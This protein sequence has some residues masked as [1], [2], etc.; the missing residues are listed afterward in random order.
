MSG[1]NDCNIILVENIPYDTSETK[2]KEIFQQVGPIVS[3]R[4]IR[5]LNNVE[6]EGQ[7]LKVGYADNKSSTITNEVYRLNPSFKSSAQQLSQQQQKL[8]QQSSNSDSDKSESGELLLQN[9]LLAYDL[10][11]ILFQLDL[12]DENILKKIVSEKQP[13]RTSNTTTPIQQPIQPIQPLPVGTNLNNPF[14]GELQIQEQNAALILQLLNLTPQQIDMFPPDQRNRILTLKNLRQSTS[15]MECRLDNDDKR[16][17]VNILNSTFTG[18]LRFYNVQI[19]YIST[20]GKF[21]SKHRA[22]LTTI[23]LQKKCPRVLDWSSYSPDLNPI[24]NLW[25]IIKKKSEWDNLNPDLLSNLCAC[26]KKRLEE[27]IERKDV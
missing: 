16:V 25:A 26:M 4:A 3:F 27:V 14:V 7:K 5:N 20:K 6:M 2:L 24:E 17:I 15:G 23:L 1:L 22:K 18:L 11:R 12:V 10:F 21:L 19:H 13:E 8:L 9:P